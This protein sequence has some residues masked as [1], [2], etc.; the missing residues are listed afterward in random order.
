VLLL[1]LAVLLVAGA[2]WLDVWDRADRDGW[3]RT[4]GRVVE[5]V[6]TDCRTFQRGCDPL[7]Y[8]VTWTD[9][10]GG[11]H[12]ASFGVGAGDPEVGDPF[13]LRYRAEAPR[14]A[15][16]IGAADPVVVRLRVGAALCV[17][18]AGIGALIA[19]RR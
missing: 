13:P 4:T 5:I 11:R 8:R 1:P 7:T 18:G 17:V 12:T 15:E 6:H 10:G 19:R 16:E 2:W 3:I 14:R 9:R